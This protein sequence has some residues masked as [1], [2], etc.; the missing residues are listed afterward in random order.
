[1]SQR[2]L[3]LFGRSLVSFRFLLPVGS[4]RGLA[5]GGLRIGFRDSFVSDLSLVRFQTGLE[6]PSLVAL[7]LCLL[8]FGA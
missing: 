5:G 6:D 4:F 2:F 3:G 8:G 7:L 1:M